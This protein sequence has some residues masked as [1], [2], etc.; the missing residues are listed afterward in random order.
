MVSLFAAEMKELSNQD[1]LG[2]FNW[3][4]GALKWNL[5]CISYLQVGLN[6]LI[7][8]FLFVYFCNSLIF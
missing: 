7:T 2:R 3:P 6:I 8:F 1:Y 4:D 5:S